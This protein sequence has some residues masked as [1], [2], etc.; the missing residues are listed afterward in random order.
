MSSGSITIGNAYSKH[1]KKSSV[2]T[3]LSNRDPCRFDRF[4]PLLQL[5]WY[6][7]LCDFKLFGDDGMDLALSLGDFDVSAFNS[8]SANPYNLMT[9]KKNDKEA[10]VFQVFEALFSHFLFLFDVLAK[11]CEFFPSYDDLF[12]PLLL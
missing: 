6:S 1:R 10:P 9:T 2:N 3:S 7:F 11:N 5:K 4:Q 12:A 8:S